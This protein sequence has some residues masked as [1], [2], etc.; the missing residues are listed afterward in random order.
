M[1]FRSC[2]TW[3]Q[4]LL[5]SPGSVVG[6]QGLR[7]STTCGVFPG[8]G[9]NPC[10]LHWQADSLPLSHQGSP[11]KYILLKNADSD[12]VGLEQELRH[13]ISDWLPGDAATLLMTLTSHESNSN[14]A[15]GFR[16]DLSVSEQEGPLGMTHSN[17]LMVL[18]GKE[19]ARH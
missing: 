5:Q 9:S 17:S 6:A 12:S 3:A 8:Q 18:I 13:G 1:S 11:N 19:R 4:S 10:L 2:G 15:L 7:C 16:Q 14:V